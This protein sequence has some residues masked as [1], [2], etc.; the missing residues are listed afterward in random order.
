MKTVI[1]VAYAIIIMVA[2]I[3]HD[4]KS[5]M[6]E[7]PSAACRIVQPFCDDLPVPVHSHVHN[8]GGTPISGASVTLTLQG[9]S[10]P[11][12]SGT[13]NSSGDCNFSSVNQGNYTYK[14]SATGYQEKTANLS[15]HVET[16]RDD[17]LVP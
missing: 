16:Y 14:V 10:T 4:N 8:S 13:T 7:D 5:V 12:Y 15:L 6:K 2:G 17:T 9:T 1:W 11:Q 3:N